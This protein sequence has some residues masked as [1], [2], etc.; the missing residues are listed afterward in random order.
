MDIDL[1]YLTEPNESDKTVVD[2]LVYMVDVTDSRSPYYSILYHP[3]GSPNEY[4]G[5]GSYN[6]FH[7][8]EWKEKYFIVKK[9]G[10]T[11]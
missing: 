4:E 2:K 11:K 1:S 10:D 3:I 8:K 5:F 9:K 6:Q 7:V